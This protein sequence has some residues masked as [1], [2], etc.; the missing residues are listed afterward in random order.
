MLNAVRG[1]REETRGTWTGGGTVKGQYVSVCLRFTLEILWPGG[2][3][4]ELN[5]FWG[6]PLK[7]KRRP[8][9][10]SWILRPTL[11]LSKNTTLSPGW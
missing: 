3:G 5:S 6:Q 7:K 2:R 4:R 1:K 10:Q 9:V 11:S 8:V